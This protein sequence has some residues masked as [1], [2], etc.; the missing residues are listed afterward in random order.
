M[1]SAK[2]GAL[3]AELLTGHKLQVVRV[4]GVEEGAR[5]N[6]GLEKTG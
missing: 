4:Q 2:K 5:H 3:M 1:D 6:K